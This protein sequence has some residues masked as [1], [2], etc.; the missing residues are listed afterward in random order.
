MIVLVALL[1]CKDPAPEAL[2]APEVSV[3]PDEV[4]PTLLHVSWTGAA[5]T[6]VGRVRY[7]MDG[8]L[9]GEVVEAEPTAVHAVRFLGLAAG[10]PATIEVEELDGDGVVLARATVELTLDDPPVD[11]ARVEEVQ[12]PEDPPTDHLMVSS[13]DVETGVASV[14]VVD[15]KGRPLWWIPP[16]NTYAGFA[17]LRRDGAALLLPR[18]EPAF[19]GGPNGS[20]AHVAWDGAQDWWSTPA[21]HH[22]VVELADGTLL[23]ATLE[24]RQYQDM[25]LAADT[26]KVFGHDGEL[27]RVWSAWDHYE[28]EENRCWDILETPEGAAEWTHANGLDVDE[29]QGLALVSLYCQEAVVAVDLENGAS[30]WTLGGDVGTL[31]LLGDPGFGP[32]HAPRFTEGGV[33]LFDNNEVVAE[34]SRVVEY[35]VDPFAGTAELRGEWRPDGHPWTG[36]LGEA[37]DYSDGLL[38]SWGIGGGVYYVDATGQVLGELKVESPQSVG[39]VAGVPAMPLPE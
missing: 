3:V 13:V 18:T 11:L 5:G 24:T 7:G 2:P 25:E 28:V 22:D 19:E 27:R 4:V 12:V 37:D 38:V 10:H 16:S 26:L 31:A 21:I 36:V 1:A 6:T 23:A 30:P 9:D 14:Q 15:W 17:R 20:V 39:S 33:R 29:A 32:Q 34:G 35:G 8:E